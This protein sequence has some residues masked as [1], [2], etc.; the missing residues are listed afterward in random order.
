MI[1]GTVCRTSEVFG[2]DQ[3]FC[4]GYVIAIGE[5]ERK[6]PAGIYTLHNCIPPEA[7]WQQTVDVVKRYLDQHPEQRHYAAVNLVAMALAEAY[8]CKP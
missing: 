4:S 6:V 3:G 5:A 8:P 2:W 1:S 7:T